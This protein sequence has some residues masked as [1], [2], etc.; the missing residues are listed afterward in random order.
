MISLIDVGAKLDNQASHYSQVSVLCRRVKRRSTLTISK[1]DVS[2]E[3]LD[4]ALHHSHVTFVYCN[5]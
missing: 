5:V 2:A 1:V 4:Q 3:L